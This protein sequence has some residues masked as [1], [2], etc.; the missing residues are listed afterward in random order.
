MEDLQKRLE[1]ATASGASGGV[2][3]SSQPA[4]QAEVLPEALDAEVAQW[5]A[6]WQTFG[7]LLDSAEQSWPD[8]AWKL[9]SE[10]L[11]GPSVSPGW[12][13]AG[14]VRRISASGWVRWAMVT[15]GIGFVLVGGALLL[16]SV[17]HRPAG[18]AT[19][20]GLASNSSQTAD[21]AARSLLFLPSHSQPSS[22]LPERQSGSPEESAVVRTPMPAKVPASQLSA[23]P[24]PLSWD[25]QWEQTILSIHQV[26]RQIEGNGLFQN[27]PFTGIRQK[28]QQIQTELDQAAL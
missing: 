5:Q 10:C 2:P 15:A 24:Q 20:S 9:P 7:R 13:Q 12:R 16:C 26:S 11:A 22:S 1:A 6:V 17:A 4:G 3:P 25:D 21:K 14:S 28:I 27:D 19:P 8:P 23:N 18:P